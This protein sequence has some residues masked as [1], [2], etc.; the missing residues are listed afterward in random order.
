M[1]FYTTRCE[2]EGSTCNRQAST[3]PSISRTF[4]FLTPLNIHGDHFVCFF[5]FSLFTSSLYRMTVENKLVQTPAVK[6][7]QKSYKNACEF[8]VSS[9]FAL[10]NTF[11]RDFFVRLFISWT[12]SAGS[13]ANCRNDRLLSSQACCMYLKKRTS[14]PKR[15]KTRKRGSL[16]GRTADDDEIYTTGIS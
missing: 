15:K 1:G 11:F 12:I 2:Y 16:F 10:F 4:R 8:P 3:S 14:N 9:S 13:L 6:M 7:E 5:L